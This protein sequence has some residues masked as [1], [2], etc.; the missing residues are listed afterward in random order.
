[1]LTRDHMKICIENEAYTQNIQPPLTT[2]EREKILNSLD[3]IDQQGIR[4]SLTGCKQ[5]PSLV[6]LASKRS[7][8]VN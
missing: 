8:S 1:M 2:D 3:Y 6:M 5:I 4:Y 7:H